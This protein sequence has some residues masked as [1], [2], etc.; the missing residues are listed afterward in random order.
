[1]TAILT[2][3]HSGAEMQPWAPGSA[4]APARSK[5]FQVRV[6]KMDRG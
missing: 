6:N 1:M 2:H 5:W 3:P 4:A